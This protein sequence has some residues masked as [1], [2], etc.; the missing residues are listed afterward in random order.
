MSSNVISGAAELSRRL[1]QFRN[2]GVSVGLVPTM[3]ALHAGH[4]AL[5][6]RARRENDVVVVSIFV[7]PLQFDR[8]TDLELYPRDLN[9][10]VAFCEALRT[11]IVYA[12]SAQ[13]L[14][15]RE[16]LA[17][18]EVPALEPFLCGRYRPGHFRGVATVVLKLLN[19]VRP[20]RAYFGEKDAQQL[21]IMRRMVEDLNVPCSIV[22]VATVRERDG[23]AMSSR[24]VRLTPSERQIAPILYAAL[25]TA[26][27]LIDAGERCMSLV[28]EKSIAPLLAQP[29]LKLEYFEICDPDTLEPLGE[30]RSSALIAGAMF[31]GDVRLIDNVLWRRK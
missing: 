27:A 30:L 1:A 14:Y 13:D 7:N 4:G 6:E 3:G 21:A 24:N 29:A 22:P 15:P 31:L 8:K 20:H 23:L 26:C 2:G 25:N 16:Q 9:A 19:I 18:A 11:D 28:R 12:P 10:D 5:M 17:F